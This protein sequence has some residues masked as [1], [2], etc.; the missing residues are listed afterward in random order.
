MSNNYL[1]GK[2]SWWKKW[3]WEGKENWE[4]RIFV[5]LCLFQWIYFE[6]M[7]SELKGFIL[8]LN[9]LNVALS[10]L[11][12]LYIAPICL[13]MRHRI[14]LT[15]WYNF[16]LFTRAFVTPGMEVGGGRFTFYNDES[17]IQ[18]PSVIFLT[19]T[20]RWSSFKLWDTINFTQEC[21]HRYPLR[22]L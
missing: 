19:G 16:E 8:A 4:Y 7:Y 14:I 6:N 2:L 5:L 22:T 17:Y 21:S 9:K 13:F 20:Q 12:I 11:C 1:S 10:L 15:P 18:R 3:T